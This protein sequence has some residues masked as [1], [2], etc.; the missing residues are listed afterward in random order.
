MEI[1]IGRELYTAPFIWIP[2]T[3]CRIE[4]DNK[5]HRYTC[6]Q[7]FSLAKVQIGDEPRRI[8]GIRIVNDD[9][10]QIVYSWKLEEPDGN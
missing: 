7:T 10:K 6:R 9:T 8:E 5:S 2:S 4:Q 3:A 1:P